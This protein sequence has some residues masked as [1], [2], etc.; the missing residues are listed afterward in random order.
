M[1]WRG[2]AGSFENR[3]PR[4]GRGVLARAA[5]LLGLAVSVVDAFRAHLTP[6]QGTGVRALG[7]AV[8]L[9]GVLLRLWSMRT[10]AGAFSYDLKVAEGQELVEAGP[11]RL[12][13]HPSYTGMLLWS[14][15]L[16][17][18]NPSLPGLLLLLPATLAQLAQRIDVEE[19]ILAEHFGARWEG[20]A[21]RTSKVIPGI[22]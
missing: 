14:A 5:W 12:V 3:V 9:S 21:R 18:W 19:R 6:W 1:E 22:W 10:L 13:R 7:V 2:I 20:Y 17:L 4:S 11:Y 8:G 16:G 15:G